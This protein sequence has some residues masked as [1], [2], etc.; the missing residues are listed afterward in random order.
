[1]SWG[2][3]RI[4]IFAVGHDLQLLHWSFNDA[5]WV[6][7]QPLGGKL[8][9]SPVAVSWEPGRLDVFWIDAETNQLAWKFWDGS[10][11]SVPQLLR[12]QYG[13]LPIEFANETRDGWAPIYN[14]PSIS[15]VS[16]GPCF[17]D[18]FV[19]TPSWSV[20]HWSYNNG[21]WQEPGVLP[22]FTP[23]DEGGGEVT[24]PTAAVSWGPDRIDAFVLCQFNIAWYSWTN[25]G[26][27]GNGWSVQPISVQPMGVSGP[28]PYGLPTAVAR[29]LGQMDLFFQSLPLPPSA[30]QLVHYAYDPSV[31][32]NW[33]GGAPLGGVMASPPCA[34]SWGPDRLD[35]FSAVADGGFLQHWFW[36][37]SGGWGG[38]ETIYG[39]FTGQPT[40]VSFAQGR[41][42]IFGID[43]DSLQLNHWWWT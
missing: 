38:P 43:A 19:V 37:S 39:F 29:A 25:P 28:V 42:D 30:S 16:L 32:G 4:D 3:D 31:P 17:L 26:T 41:L 2:P 40:A 35:V 12:V 15:A 10:S 33:S 6:G 22:D 1:V 9:T 7:P 36:D 11:W 8:A 5:S 23:N 34:V 21:A 27:S 14:T 20:M 24:G 18:V 13:L